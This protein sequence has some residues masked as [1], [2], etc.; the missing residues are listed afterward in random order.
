M[1]VVCGAITG[2]VPRLD[3]R[4]DVGLAVTVRG[5]SYPIDLTDEPWAL[6][7]PV[8][9][10]PS[11]MRAQ[12]A[13]DL[14]GVVDAMLCISHIRCQSRSLPESFVPWTRVCSK[15]HRWSR[16]GLGAGPGRA[17]RARTLSGLSSRRDPVAGGH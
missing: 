15:F 17:A 3:V 11:K 14:P 7:E 6:L 4:V 10:P 13:P 8:C 16:N 2:G 5:M 12:A 9:N 1:T